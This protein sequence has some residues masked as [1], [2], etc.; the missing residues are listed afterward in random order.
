M[1]W[2]CFKHH[3]ARLNQGLNHHVSMVFS[4]FNHPL[5]VML[6]APFPAPPAASRQHIGLQVDEA[7]MVVAKQLGSEGGLHQ[8]DPWDFAMKKWWLSMV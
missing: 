3:V 2:S 1:D 5:F 8:G 6:K 4:M 7:Q